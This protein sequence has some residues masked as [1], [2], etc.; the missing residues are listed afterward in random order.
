ML[1]N[2]VRKRI[3]HNVLKRF[4]AK[5]HPEYKEWTYADGFYCFCE[6]KEEADI[7]H[8]EWL[9]DKLKTNIYNHEDVST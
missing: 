9:T 2:E 1:N 4:Y 7:M 6:S 8:D 5:R 3:V